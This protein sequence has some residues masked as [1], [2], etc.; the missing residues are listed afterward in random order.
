M[1]SP[2]S[3]IQSV[4]AVPQIQTAEPTAAPKGSGFKE[5]IEGAIQ[6]VEASRQTADTQVAAFLNGTGGEL[7]ST[8]LSAQRAELQFELF[9][10]CR[11][12]VVSAYQEI[13]RVQV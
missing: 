10:Q 11:N 9:L 3:L 12:K 4:A 8:L 5:F 6:S 7:H 2:I 13:M 1:S